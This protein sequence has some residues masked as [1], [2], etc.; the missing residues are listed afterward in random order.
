MSEAI[1]WWL[2]LLLAGAVTLPL[3]LA[4]FRRLPDRGYTLSKPFALLF[5][6]F[7]FWFL[8]SL[9]L[10][11]NTRGGIIFALMLLG[12]VSGAVAYRDRADLRAWAE[13]RW[14]Y[15]LGVEIGFLFV[16]M[17]AVWLRSLVGQISGTE[18]P[19]DLMFVNATMRAE[20]FPPQDPWLSGHTVAY[21]YFGYLLVGMMGT[22]ADVPAAVAYNIGL[23]MIASLTLVAAFGIVYN[24]VKMRE[25]A[26]AEDAPVSAAAAT[27]KAQRPQRRRMMA[28]AAADASGTLSSGA[29]PPID[30]KPFAFG[31]AGALMLVVMGNLVWLLKFASAY[32]IGGSGF[33]GWVDVSGLTA[34]E[35][36]ATWYPSEFFGFFDA[37]RIYP[38]NND[39][40]RVITEFPMFSFLLGDLHPHVMALPFVLLVA[41][42]ALTLYRSEEPLDI[43]FWLQRPLLLVA[44]AIMLGGLA[45]LNTWDIATMAFVVVAAAS[46]SNFGRVRSLTLELFVQTATFALPL[47]ITAILF[48]LPFYTSF[49]SQ[50]DSILPVLTRPG[51]TEPG[52]RPFHALLYWGPLFTVV[53]PF[54]AVRLIVARDRIVRRDV[55]IALAIP[56]AIVVGWALLFA[57]VKLR[58]DPNVADAGGFIEQILDRGADWIT[59][60]AFGG[61][62][63]AALLAL[64][65]ELTSDEERAERAGAVFALLLASTAFLLIF[66]TEFYYVGDVFN[67]RMNTVFKLYY[68]AWLLL[69][70]AGGFALYYLASSWRFTFHNEGIF[71]I[72]WAAGVGIVIVGAALYPLGATFD[73][74][75]PYN[76]GGLIVERHGLDGIARFPAGELEAIEWLTGLAQHQ[77]IVIAEAFCPAPDC[78]GNDYS[79]ASRISGSTGAPAILGWAGHE[80][81]WRGGSSSARAGRF[82][83]VERLFKTRDMAEVAEIVEKYGVTYIY[84]GPLERRTYDADALDKFRSLP[85]A[86]ESDAKAGANGTERPEVTV[87]Q[88]Q[89]AAGEGSTRP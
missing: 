48:Y 4:V 55:L 23:G 30:W 53:A 21:Y 7:T 59:V 14:A 68:Q 75:R 80:D 84:V 62:L 83:D 45:F 79:E 57:F 33:Y 40:F 82:E 22:F 65:L 25:D 54:V 71:R 60:L 89:G 46:V 12:A 15:V 10:I 85:I 49:T 51:V 87:Y 72:G 20:H 6:G 36:R 76:E 35:A 61:V 11:P 39:D 9:Q 2:I 16:F 69:A 29:A 64:W 32:G 27:P 47:L 8:N 26:I 74:L 50:A 67:V 70:L 56:V 73:R 41:A 42:L 88:A 37:S 43:T 52:T 17:M 28:D 13:R 31:A 24:L 18:Q 34:D 66:G 58:S 44:A 5:L 1:R 3:C 86:F 63:A 81:Q 19:M 77:E 38:V 78:R